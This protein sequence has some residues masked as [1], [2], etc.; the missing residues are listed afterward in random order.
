MEYIHH[1]RSTDQFLQYY[2]IGV[3]EGGIFT[4]RTP[5]LEAHYFNNFIIV[6]VSC[7]Y[8]RFTT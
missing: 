4:T 6:T 8:Y 2:I 1:F 7:F 5:K 3:R